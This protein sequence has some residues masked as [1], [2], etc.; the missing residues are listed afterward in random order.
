MATDGGPSL[1]MAQLSHSA[2][3]VR[4][5]G[6][7]ADPATERGH[8]SRSSHPPCAVGDS[9]LVPPDPGT[10]IEFSFDWIDAE[11]GGHTLTVS[12]RDD[13][14]A[15]G[16]SDP[17]RIIVERELELPVVTIRTTDRLG[18]EPSP[19]QTFAPQEH[20]GLEIAK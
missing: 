19:F 8:C 20:V 13:R 1:V 5:Q 11:P 6:S 2:A 12:T 7:P 3:R 14:G 15:R 10:P 18:T 4:R 17:V 9:Q 16:H